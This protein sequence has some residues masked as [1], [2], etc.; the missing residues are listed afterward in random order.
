[1]SVLCGLGGG[2]EIEGPGHAN[3]TKHGG[4]AAGVVDGGGAFAGRQLARVV[5]QV[6]GPGVAGNGPEGFLAHQIHVAIVAFAD[7]VKADQG[8]DAEG[9]DLALIAPI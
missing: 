4:G 7:G 6:D 9:V 8:I 5:Y 2:H 3:R 1:L